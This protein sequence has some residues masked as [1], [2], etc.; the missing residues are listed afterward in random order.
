M[1][2]YI[3]GIALGTCATLAI[4]AMFLYGTQRDDALMYVGD[5]VDIYAQAGGM[6]GTPEEKWNVYA[7]H[8]AARYADR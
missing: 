4:V 6:T 2:E 5:C 7:G 8:C 3:K 1:T